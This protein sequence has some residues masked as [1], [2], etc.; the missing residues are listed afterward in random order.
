MEHAG[1]Q[2]MMRGVELSTGK[3]LWHKDIVYFY[4]H[5]TGD[6]TLYYTQ[7]GVKVYHVRTG[8]YIRMVVS[9]RYEYI[10]R[11]KNYALNRNASYI[12]F[13]T[14]KIKWTYPVSFRNGI[15]G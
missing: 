1:S 3:T 14:G 7:N 4:I 6:Y 15:L 8:E 5:F 12:D 13:A 11:E 10:D 2:G 9:K